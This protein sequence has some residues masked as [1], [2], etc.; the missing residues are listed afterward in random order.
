ML[1]SLLIIVLSNCNS[2]SD[3]EV[4]SWISVENKT[5][6]QAQSFGRKS[7]IRN[8]VLKENCN[9]FRSFKQAMNLRKPKRAPH[10]TLLSLEII[11]TFFI[12]IIIILL[13]FILKSFFFPSQSLPLPLFAYVCVFVWACA[14]AA[15]QMPLPSSKDTSNSRL[16]QSLLPW[17]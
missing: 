10:F 11:I 15:A 5:V 3:L 14:S 2:L 1:I 8:L 4:C 17:S 13:P 16:W 6:D 7:F 12:N 9:H